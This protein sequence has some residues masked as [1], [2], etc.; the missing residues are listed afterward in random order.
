MGTWN[1]RDNHQ[2]H[3]PVDAGLWDRH[4]GH[5]YRSYGPSCCGDSPKIEVNISIPELKS[6]S[7]LT[8]TERFFRMRLTQLLML[9]PKKRPN[10]NIWIGK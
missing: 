9:W 5:C 1:S 10:G 3:L 8:E 2:H 7:V 6:L 4:T